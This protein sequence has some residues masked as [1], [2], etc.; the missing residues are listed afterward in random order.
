MAMDVMI[1]GG[2]LNEILGAAKDPEKEG[3]FCNRAGR[4]NIPDVCVHIAA[5][6]GEL[7][8]AAVRDSLGLK[9]S[10]FP[11]QCAVTDRWTPDI[12]EMNRMAMKRSP[13]AACTEGSLST[14]RDDVWRA[15]NAYD[16]CSSHDIL[17]VLQLTSTEWGFQ[18]VTVSHI[19]LA[20]R[21]ALTCDVLRL[22]GIHDDLRKWASAHGSRIWTCV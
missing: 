5:A 9:L 4:R 16:L 14:L 6:V 17:P 22:L 8:W 2:V 15:A 7:R 20:L 11:F 21:V 1:D 12:A 13:N 10:T 3:L 19:E 18:K